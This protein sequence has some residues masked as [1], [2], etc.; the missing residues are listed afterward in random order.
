MT[1]EPKNLVVLEFSYGIIKGRKEQVAQVHISRHG[2]I[3]RDPTQ[4]L[5]QQHRDEIVEA[6]QNAF[7]KLSE[8]A[9][10]AWSK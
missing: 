4:S 3:V 7:T 2:V 8:V 1:K 6:A 5:T 9:T 10:K